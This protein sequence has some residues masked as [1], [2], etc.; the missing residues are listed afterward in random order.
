MT[1]LEWAVLVFA[2]WL[3]GVVAV[4]TLLVWAATL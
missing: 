3:A 1:D 4:S 2:A